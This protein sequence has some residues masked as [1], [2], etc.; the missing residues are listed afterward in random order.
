MLNRIQAIMDAKG[1]SVTTFADEIGVKRP[2]MNHTM[3]GR[4]N[5][6]LDTIT[7]ILERYTD[8][9]PE[10]LLFGTGQMMRSNIP[11]QQA[12]FQ[13]EINVNETIKPQPQSGVNEVKELQISDSVAS[14]NLQ[15]RQIDKIMV[16]YS[17]CS[18]E[19]F[20][21]EITSKK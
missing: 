7:K 1:L 12:L 9:S 10:W 14:M 2:A 20:I 5:P 3:S 16:F 4:N 18:F 8:I 21:P 6:S 19:T 15:K 17:D 11:I 13:E